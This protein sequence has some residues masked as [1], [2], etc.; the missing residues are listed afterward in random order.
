MMGT[1]GLYGCST[2]ETPVAKNSLMPSPNSFFRASGKVPQTSEKFTPPFSIRLPCCKTR[3]C[4]PPP[5]WCFQVSFENL[6]FPSSPSRLVQ[7]S[8]CMDLKASAIC[9][10]VGS[11]IFLGNKLVILVTQNVYVFVEAPAG[12]VHFGENKTG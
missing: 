10:R 9:W 3:L 4:P 7:I 8:A 1:L 11:F 12:L 2:M 6:P 5:S